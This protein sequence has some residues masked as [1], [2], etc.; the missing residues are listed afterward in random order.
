MVVLR[1]IEHTGIDLQGWMARSTPPRG[2]APPP[3]DSGPLKGERVAIL[4]E[5]R[6]GALAR[7]VAGAGGRIVAAVGAT[8]TMLVIATRHPYGRWVEAS[9]P[10]RRAEQLRKAGRPIRVLTEEV[11]RQRLM[12]AG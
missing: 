9:E 5:P 11:L 1:A 3:A 2:K 12:H 4:G 7:C 6:D 8:T 10:H